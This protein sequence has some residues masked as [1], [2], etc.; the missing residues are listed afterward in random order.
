MC[1]N[2]HMHSMCMCM[3]MCVSG[4]MCV[5]FLL[6]RT[7]EDEHGLVVPTACGLWARL[8][9][10][11]AGGGQSVPRAVIEDGAGPDRQ[12]KDG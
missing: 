8:S 11:P 3:C 6:A 7:M 10:H 5:T 9:A 1:N 4:C 12:C 2:M